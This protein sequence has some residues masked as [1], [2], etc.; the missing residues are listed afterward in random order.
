MSDLITWEPCDWREVR[1]GDRVAPLASWTID[2][3]AIGAD[4]SWIAVNLDR[5]RE[6]TTFD[7]RHGWNNLYRLVDRRP[8][9]AAP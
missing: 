6:V 4:G 1:A 9:H 3:L 2:V 7:N 5:P 8:G